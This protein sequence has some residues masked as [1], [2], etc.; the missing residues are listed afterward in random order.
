MR[1]YLESAA[2]GDSGVALSL[3]AST[4]SFAKRMSDSLDELRLVVFVDAGVVEV[5]APLTAV[6][7]YSLSG[8]GVGMRLKALHGLVAGLD[9]AVA[10]NELG[11]TKQG[12]GRIYFK[13]GYEW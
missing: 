10:L 12:D 8:A 11:K 13:L 9:L 1:G 6:D 3:E 5:Q 2:A 4:P 7:Q